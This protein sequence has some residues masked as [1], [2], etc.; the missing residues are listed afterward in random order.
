MVQ[1][2]GLE[3]QGERGGFVF[4]APADT[5]HVRNRASEFRFCGMERQ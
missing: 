5:I 1:V 3:I 2:N 4:H